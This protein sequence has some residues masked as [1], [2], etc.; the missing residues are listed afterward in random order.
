MARLHAYTS[1][2][3]KTHLAILALHGANVAKM[4]M[5]SLSASALVC[6]VE[7][8]GQTTRQEGAGIACALSDVDEEHVKSAAR[9]GQEC[10]EVDLHTRIHA[11]LITMTTNQHARSSCEPYVLDRFLGAYPRMLIP[12]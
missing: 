7:Q 10:C 9:E 2:Q 5:L 8:S 3:Q 11:A 4:D 1:R 12:C 6:M